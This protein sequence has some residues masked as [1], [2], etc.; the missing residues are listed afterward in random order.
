MSDI[1]SE[2]CSTCGAFN[3]SDNAFCSNGFHAPAQP[4]FDQRTAATLFEFGIG[5]KSRLAQLLA[6]R[7]AAAYAEGLAS[8]GVGRLQS[9]TQRIREKLAYEKGRADAEASGRL[10][11]GYS[12]SDERSTAC[13]ALSE[14][15][16]LNGTD[17]RRNICYLAG[18]A[19]SVI[20]D[21]NR[22]VAELRRHVPAE[23]KA[24][25]E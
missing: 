14:A 9:D 15:L 11:T 7:E 4:N 21:Y 2:R 19:E 23:P 25:R 13:E 24:G 3:P 17:W 1:T 10:E 8:R 16:G 6:T 20:R 22:L 5:E 18:R 12:A